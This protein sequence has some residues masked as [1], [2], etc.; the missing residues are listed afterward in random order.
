MKRINILAVVLVATSMLVVSCK[1][2]ST[3]KTEEG[4]EQTVVDTD[5]TSFTGND[6]HNAQNSLDWAGEYSGT[7]PCASCPGI[8]LTIVL[9]D[10][11]TYSKT[12]VY[13]EKKDGRFEELGTFAWD[14]T[15]SIVTLTSKDDT[16]SF[17][18]HEGSILLL[19]TEGN[20]IT[21][22]LANM[23]VLTKK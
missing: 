19:D 20:E 9:N 22:E 18:V 15:G 16:S 4:T 2:E 10:D 17:K 7:I 12:S 1:K 11:G 23:Y 6:G 8:D 13:Q 14:A 21:G 5:D 3:A